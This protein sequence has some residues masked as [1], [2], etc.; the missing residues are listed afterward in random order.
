LLPESQNKVFLAPET[1]LDSMKYTL[2]ENLHNYNGISSN[3]HGFVN[4]YLDTGFKSKWSGYWAP[5][6]KFLD[7]Y[8]LKIN[9]IWLD[10]KTLEATEYGENFT[11]HHETDSLS[12]TEKVETPD[13]L[14][15]FRLKLEIE[16]RTDEKKAVHTVFEPGIDI[17]KVDQDLG[18]E[19]YHLKEE[20]NELSVSN[21]QGKLKIKSKD[22]ERKEDPYIKEHY[23]DEKQR[24]FI[25]GHLVFRRE[26]K[27][28]QT[29]TLEIEFTTSE[30][31]LRTI[32]TIEQD[33]QHS[34]GRTFNSSIDSLE[35]LVYDKN[36]LGIIAGHPWFQ[37]YWARDT[38]WSVLGLVD[39]GYFEVSHEI[40]QNFAQKEIPGK[41]NL[42]GTEEQLERSDTKP[43]FIIAAD[44]LQR[45]YKISK[46]IE[47]A[48]EKSM[49]DL[50]LEDNIVKHS[51]DG[52]WMDTI[53]RD[54]AVDIQS[55]W[56]KAADIMN[57]DRKQKL[58]KGLK[59][60]EAKDHIKDEL[61][62]GSEAINPVIPLMFDQISS[63]VAEKQLEKINGEF[64]SRFGA[65]TRSAMDP[66]Y[67]SDG[68]H[69]GSSWGL[70]T[71][72]AAAA[73]LKN[74][75]KQQGKNFL[76][77]MELFL[78][79]DQPG[80]LPEVADSESGEL[81]GCPEQAWSAGLFIHTVDTY[82]LGIK[83]EQD[84]I[85]I[86]PCEGLDAKRFGKRIRGETLDLEIKDGTV[87]ILNNPD[88][89]IRTNN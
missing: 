24:C 59:Q 21:Q 5:P 54:K 77:K 65:R 34:L 38:F 89:D 83:V 86:D 57:D 82:L 29:K 35:N 1:Q 51:V 8:A 15:G 79:R 55:L 4:R 74:G 48:M 47:K 78:D 66:G 9:G 80:A 26:I 70:T 50:E 76:K 41:I 45:H 69:T 88:L 20:K 53:K 14:A 46:Q 13:N 39:A 30:D 18:P 73:N 11:Y 12:I 81:L 23:P 68:Y 58:E 17:R 67:K 6:Y 75:K 22:F 27:A 71:G 25:P 32:K 3:L 33:L 72:W 28:G 37:S 42:D 61:E 56:L 85:E 16:N 10:P 7:Y 62:D 44:K 2:H 43:L 64:S 36:G 31:D 52:T 60:F 40:L 63:D 84:H 87:N 49:E 19:D